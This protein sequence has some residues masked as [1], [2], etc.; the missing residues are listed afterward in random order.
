MF[1]RIDEFLYLIKVNGA[2]SEVKL[3]CNVT[4]TIKLLIIK[5]IKQIS[6]FYI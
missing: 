3:A 1:A 2:I 5:N 4:L 6:N